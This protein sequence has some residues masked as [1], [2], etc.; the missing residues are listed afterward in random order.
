MNHRFSSPAY[1][2]ALQSKKRFFYFYICITI[3]FNLYMSTF[4]FN[5]LLLPYSM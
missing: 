5:V 2:F 4:N 1:K 3:V